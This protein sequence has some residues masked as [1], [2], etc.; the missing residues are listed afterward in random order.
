VQPLLTVFDYAVLAI[1][2]LSA[3]IGLVR[4]AVREVLAVAGW[5]L[6]FWVATSYA[7]TAVRYAPLALSN[8]SLR[9]AAAFIVLFLITLIVVGFAGKLFTTLIQKVGL[10]PFDRL[11]GLVVGVARGVLIV[12]VLVIIGGLTALPRQSEWR[13][14]MS[15]GWFES[16]ALGVKSWLPPAL[17]KRI[18][19]D[20]A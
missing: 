7:L 4:G 19:F 16:M 9:L 15:S 14:A 1:I 10:G 8:P 3:F 18:G 5:V 6:A 13:N 11:L 12:L 17:A 2:G 20:E